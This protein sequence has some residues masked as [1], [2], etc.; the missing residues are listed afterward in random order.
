MMDLVP[1]L[2]TIILVGTVVLLLLVGAVVWLVVRALRSRPAGPSLRP[3]EPHA[4][5]R[6]LDP[7]P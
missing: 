3:D 4:S 7:G 2:S 6:P 5:A 1:I